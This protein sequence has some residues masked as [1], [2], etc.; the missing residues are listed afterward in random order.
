[1]KL[2]ISK[3]TYKQ[4]DSSRRFTK[5]IQFWVD[6]VGVELA[7]TLSHYHHVEDIETYEVKLKKLEKYSRS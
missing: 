3:F 2:Y 7:N 4:K 1:M 5:E 6:D